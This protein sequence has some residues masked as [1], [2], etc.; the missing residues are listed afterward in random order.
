MKIKKLIMVKKEI[1]LTL[2]GVFALL[3]NTTAAV[4]DNRFE[5]TFYQESKIKGGQ[6]AAFNRSNTIE[7][8]RY[9]ESAKNHKFG[10]TVNSSGKFF[11][12]GA[13]SSTEYGFESSKK[14]GYEKSNTSSMAASSEIS[15]DIDKTSGYK[16]AVTGRTDDMSTVKAATT[17]ISRFQG[18]YNRAVKQDDQSKDRFFTMSAMSTATKQVNDAE[19]STRKKTVSKNNES[20]FNKISK[21]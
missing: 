16:V 4:D 8:K 19:E 18:T 12:I 1:L 7:E 9:A 21:K 13:E 3:S 2:S 17:V 10:Q 6:K 11:G 14:K 5:G 20:L 15:S